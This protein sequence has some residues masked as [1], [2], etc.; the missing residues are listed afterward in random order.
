M[1]ISEDDKKIALLA[2]GRAHADA[3]AAELNA[4]QDVGVEDA[5]ADTDVPL[6]MTAE[7]AVEFLNSD[8]E[9][10]DL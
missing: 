3:A 8:R 5:V 7:S 9:L 2:K 10:V 4:I 1:D 6:K